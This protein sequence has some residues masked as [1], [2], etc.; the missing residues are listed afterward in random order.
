V[1][2]GHQVALP[3]ALWLCGAS[4]IVTVDINPY[5]SEELVQNDIKFMRDNQEKVLKIF[6]GTKS[7]DQ[8]KSRLPILFSATTSLENL[9]DTINLV[10]LCPADA[11]ALPLDD[12]SVDFHVSYT[13][14]E[15]IPPDVIRE[16]LIEGTRVLN[17]GG[18]FVHCVDFS[19]HFA[20]SDESIS[21]VNFLQYS[22]R[23]WQFL[24]ANR[25][26]YHNRL[27][28]DDCLELFE[29][30]GLRILA[31]DSTV[32]EEAVMLLK[33]GILDVSEPFKSKPIEVNATLHSWI[34]ALPS[35]DE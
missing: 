32:D 35:K 11:A 12:Q 28:V 24:A 23:T 31:S 7:F 18:L 14:F 19:D 3:I 20:H 25:Y 16:I 27:R 13:V 1:G 26:A 10:Y 5:L 29:Q 34:V 9:L 15:H 21:S 8:V 4:R 30:C 2:T 22:E 6:Q 33:R 17:S